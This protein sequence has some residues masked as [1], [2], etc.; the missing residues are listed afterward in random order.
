VF[1]VPPILF[2]FLPRPQNLWVEVYEAGSQRRKNRD[3]TILSKMVLG[4]C[5]LSCI[6]CTSLS[7]EQWQ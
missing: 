4:R 7:L 6:Y 3:R 2:L 1:F 5:L